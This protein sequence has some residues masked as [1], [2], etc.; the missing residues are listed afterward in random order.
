M[1]RPRNRVGALGSPSWP[2]ENDAQY[3]LTLARMTEVC[4]LFN[5]SWTHHVISESLKPALNAYNWEKCLVKSR[6]S[7][8]KQPLDQP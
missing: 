5:T 3:L 8:N 1:T 4:H 6:I 7:G 2:V